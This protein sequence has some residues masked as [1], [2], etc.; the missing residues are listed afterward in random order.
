[1]RTAPNLF[2]RRLG[3]VIMAFVRTFRATQKMRALKKH[4][5]TYAWD[6]PEVQQITREWANGVLKDLNVSVKVEG[7]PTT[8]AAIFVGNHLSY[9]DIIALY[10]VQHLCFVA[11]SEVGTWPIIGEGTRIAGSI[12]VE[13]G[14]PRSRVETAETL[15]RAVAEEGRKVCI[16]PEGTTSIEGKNW[17]RGVFRVAQEKKLS[18]QPMG[19]VYKPIRRA[20]YID[21]DTLFFHMWH[22]IQAAPT[23][24]TIHFFEAR[25]IESADADMFAMQ[26]EVRAWVDLRLQEQG[27]FESDVGYLE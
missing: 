6:A 22:L 11:K 24:L 2:Y 4:A 13:R 7:S 27:F 5:K 17:R 19:F 14:S 8:E 1:M 26:K 21:D 25:K 12:F 10:S 16:F 3:G 23:E 9:I 20:A 18:M 15:G